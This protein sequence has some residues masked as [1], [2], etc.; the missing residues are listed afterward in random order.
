MGSHFDKWTTWLAEHIH[1]GKYFELLIKWMKEAG[2]GFFD[3]LRGIIDSSITFFEGIFSA[4]PSLYMILILSAL[5][6]WACGWR[7]YGLALFALIGFILV[8]VMGLWSLTME[9]LAL[10][11][12][13]TILALLIG[14]PLGV[15]GGR[16]PRTE[17]VVRPVLDFMQTM[18]AFVYLIPAIFLFQLGNVPG[19][20]AT[21]IFAMPP[22][23]RLT[24]LGLRQVPHDVL[25]ASQAFGATPFQQLFKV[26]LP[27]A[28]PSILA[29]VNQTI[30]LAL[31]MVVIAAMIGAGGLGARVYQGITQMRIGMGFEAGLAI[32]ILAMYLDRI[33]HALG[34][35]SAARQ[36]G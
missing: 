26:Q 23:V 25:E 20:I 15:L 1:V 35:R 7:R 2:G 22:C 4:A 17:R 33:T 27:L 10:V 11:I 18:P 32:V 9:T 29:G 3:A 13:S 34:S 6:W 19:A 8:D 21:L 36:K 14:I 31:S 12:A 5:A 28:L 16:S 30:M 24:T